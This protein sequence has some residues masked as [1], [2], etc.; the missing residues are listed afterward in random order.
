MKSQ[1]CQRCARDGHKTDTPSSV[2]YSS[3]VSRDSVRICLL[4]AALK[5]IDIK[6]ADI[7][8]AYLT[9][10]IWEKFY[11]WA[12]PEFEQD[13]GKPFIIVHALYELKSSGASFRAF[14][15]EHLDELGF[16]STIA[17]PDVW[18]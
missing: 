7:L 4:I 2:T 3:I 8:N 10:P 6:C 15:I 14:L 11:T 1:V 5:E 18:R 17:D 9:T 13:E 16:I 12:G